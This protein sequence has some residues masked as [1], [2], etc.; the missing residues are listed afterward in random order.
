ML[1]SLISPLVHLFYPHC[2][3][4]CGTDLP[5]TDELLCLRCQES[6]PLTCFHQYSNNPVEKIFHGRVQL[7]RAT[8]VYYYHQSSGIQ[9]L[10]HRLKYKQRADIA[11]WLGKQA[12][13]QLQE[14]SWIKD[15]TMLVPV[16]LN[17]LKEKRRGYNQAYLLAAGIAEI[18]PLPVVPK[19]LYREQFTAT[20]TRKGRAER[21]Q[22]VA[23]AFRANEQ[24]LA[25]QHVLLID[26]VV[27][28]GGHYRSLLPGTTAGRS[29]CQCM[30]HG[31]C[32]EMTT[33][34]C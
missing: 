5:G 12:G 16:P 6:L 3:E 23:A 13:C 4:L 10:I 9:Q 17:P 25:G 29:H 21:W 27:T 28:T 24:V 26:D 19:A 30:L 33:V 15:I 8:A 11:G 20:Q 31:L 7:H 14:A 18:V 1:T 32:L 34:A 22:N 2:C